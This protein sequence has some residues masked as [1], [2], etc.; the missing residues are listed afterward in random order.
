MIQYLILDRIR[1]YLEDALI[2][3]IPVDDPTRAGVVKIGDLNGEPDPDI[4]RISVTLYYNDPD[5]IVNSGPTAFGGGWSDEIQEIEVGG[6]VTHKRRFSIKIRCLFDITR[7]NLEEAVSIAST[8]RTRVEHTLHRI[9][10]SG[11]VS[12]GEYV[13]RPI[14]S[15][16]IYAETLI[17]GGPPDSYDVQAKIRFEV[18][19]TYGGTQ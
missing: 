14:L 17:G 5:P 4:A 15:T 7:E 8:V 3:T 2:N 6:F 19:T 18:L 1:T 12:D 9:S 13:A 11:V 16:D 10:F